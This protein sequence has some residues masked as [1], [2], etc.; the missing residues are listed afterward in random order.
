MNWSPCTTHPSTKRL[1]V[2]KVQSLPSNSCGEQSLK[3]GIPFWW[4]LNFSHCLV[5]PCRTTSWFRQKKEVK[6]FSTSLLL[7]VTSSHHVISCQTNS[8][9]AT[10]FH[11]WL[12]ILCLQRTFYTL[13]GDKT[14]WNC[15]L[16]AFALLTKWTPSLLDFQNKK[17]K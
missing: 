13:S 7:K 9:L 11:K 16:N 12:Q 3:A 2:P 1:S 8:T 5:T 14:L 4:S 15:N 6:L 10:N 17:K